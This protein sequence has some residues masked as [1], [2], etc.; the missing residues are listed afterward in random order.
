[1]RSLGPHRYAP[2]QTIA[3]WTV[4]RPA[5]H[6]TRAHGRLHIVTFRRVLCRCVCGTER[7]V[8]E[9]DLALERSKGC[10]SAHCRW[11]WSLK[12][13]V[14]DLERDYV[15]DDEDARARIDAARAKLARVEVARQKLPS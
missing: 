5:S 7:V 15:L 4:V 1:M 13:E 2:G 9:R 10:R 14:A 11:V 6:L 8:L 12:R 3:R